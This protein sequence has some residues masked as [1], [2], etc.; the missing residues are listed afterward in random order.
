MGEFFPKCLGVFKAAKS[1]YEHG[2]MTDQKS[3]I[4]KNL[5]GDT[6]EQARELF[7]ANFTQAA[8][9]VAGVAIE[10]KLKNLCSGINI[11]VDKPSINNYN[12]ALHK[13][14]Q[15][16][17]PTFFEIMKW[18]SIRNAA[19]HGV[20]GEFTAPQVDEMIKGITGFLDNY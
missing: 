17:Q 3:I 13:A 5:L 1:D 20:W 2:F 15:I 12:T 9:I 7:G 6:I 19:A 8:A 14:G 18:G 4:T 10:S 11:E 16:T